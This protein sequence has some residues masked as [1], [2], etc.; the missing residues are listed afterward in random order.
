MSPLA[1]GLRPSRMTSC[2]KPRVA[3]MN[4]QTPTPSYAVVSVQICL[5]AASHGETNLVER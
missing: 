2:S 4:M 5:R 3:R 1:E